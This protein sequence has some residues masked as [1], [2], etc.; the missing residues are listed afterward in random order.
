MTETN[1]FSK[2]GF[3]NKPCDVKGGKKGQKSISV[4]P[5]NHSYK[6][7]HMYEQAKMNL[8]INNIAG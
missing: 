5:Q 7:T 2:F 1:L 4:I 6:N 3:L 8:L